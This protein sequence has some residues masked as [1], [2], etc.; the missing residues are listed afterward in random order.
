MLNFTIGPVMSGETVLAIGAE[1]VPYFRTK[2]FSE[3]M[4]DNEVKIYHKSQ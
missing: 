1:Q 3:K 4:M 2:E